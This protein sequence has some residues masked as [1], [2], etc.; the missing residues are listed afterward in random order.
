MIRNLRSLGLALGVVFAFSAAMAST[1]SAIDTFTTEAALPAVVTGES[2]NIVTEITGKKVSFQCDVTKFAGTITNGSSVA[3][4]W[5]TFYKTTPDTKCKSTLGEVTYDMNGCDYDLTGKTDASD[6]T[7]TD[8]KVWITCPAGK[9]VEITGALGCTIRTPEQTPT[10]GG[11]TYTTQ[12]DASGKKDILLT[13]TMTGITYT[14]TNACT[15]VGLPTEGNDTDLTGTVTLKAFKD[16]GGVP[17]DKFIEGSQIDFTD[18]T[19]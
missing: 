4:I 16:N 7:L 13:F 17:D 10:E 11:V 19:S 2:S 1:A 6:K 9:E 8:A 15:L 14:T 12:T 5:P 18:S 3:T